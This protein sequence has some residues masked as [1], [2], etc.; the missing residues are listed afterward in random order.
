MAAPDY[1]GIKNAVKAAIDNANPPISNPLPRVVIEDSIYAGLADQSA[2][3]GGPN[4]GVVGIYMT[5]RSAAQGQ[6]LAGG[7]R[8]RY[9]VEL[10]LWV[11]WF[12]MSDLKTAIDRRD[13]LVAAVEQVLMRDRTFGG[14]V[15]MAWL[16]GGEM[17]SARDAAPF[18][19]VAGGEIKLVL[20]INFTST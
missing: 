20:E 15:A 3:G 2:Q 19:F 12:E 14:E 5:G 17:F 16:E 6:P 4:L 8:G 1:A 18:P 7:Q 10:V 13:A 11:L 9:R